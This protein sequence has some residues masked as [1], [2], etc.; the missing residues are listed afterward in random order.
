MASVSGGCASAV[1]PA[2]LL[3][4]LAMVTGGG[5]AV[6]PPAGPARPRAGGGWGIRLSLISLPSGVLGGAGAI[7]LLQQ[8]AVVYPSTGIIIA[9]LVGGLLASIVIP[10]LGFTLGIRRARRRGLK[11][12]GGKPR[13]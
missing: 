12:A 9:G 5:A 2:I 4:V 3:T 10:S 7:V 13:P 6:P 8:Y 1:L 11:A